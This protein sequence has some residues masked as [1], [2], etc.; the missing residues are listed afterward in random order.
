MLFVPADSERKL[1]R[2]R[3]CPSDALVLDLEDAVVP[4]KK[5]AA[6][7]QAARFIAQ[8]GRRSGQKLFV[9]ING[10]DSGLALADLAAVVVPGL[11]GVLLPKARDPVEVARLG[12][13]LDALEARAGMTTGGVRIAV[14]ATE[15]AQAVLSINS[16]VAPIPRLVAL[17]W[18]AEDLSVGVGAASNLDEEGRLAPLYLLAASLCLCAA[19]AVGAAAIDTVFA[20]YRDVVGLARAC[21]S[22][23]RQGFSGKLAIHPDQVDV[24]NGMFT[25]DEA[26]LE[27]ARGILAA[28]DAEPT[29]GAISVDGVMYDRPHL[30]RARRILGLVQ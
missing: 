9:R 28:F 27:K 7:Q 2:G 21:R 5:E 26:E 30:T 3:S 8:E 19:A 14:V 16:Y 24:I 22:A 18:G 15:S 25:P 29:A 4:E 12:H 23:R 13:C 10:F 17:T 20:D 11:D 1:I 6:R